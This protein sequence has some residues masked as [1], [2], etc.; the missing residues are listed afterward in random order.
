MSKVFAITD[1]NTRS[2]FTFQDLLDQTDFTDD[3]ADA[4]AHL[5]I[6]QTLDIDEFVVIRT[7]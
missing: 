2:Y 7:E 5:E 3:E 6:L 4:I 1:G